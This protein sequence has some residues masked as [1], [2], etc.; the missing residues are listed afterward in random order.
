MNENDTITND[1]WIKYIGESL[2]NNFDV[3]TIHIGDGLLAIE[4][5]GGY[6]GI[7]ERHDY[8]ELLGENIV[9][10][11]RENYDFDC[12]FEISSYGYEL[13]IEII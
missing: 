9:E 11:V 13:V 6:I 10:W 8:I 2:D 3:K 4:E 7:E 1:E 12:D 5:Y